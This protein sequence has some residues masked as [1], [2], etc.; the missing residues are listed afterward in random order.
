MILEL[1]EDYEAYKN[2]KNSNK[3]S[4]LEEHGI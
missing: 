2:I 1:L 4:L 3:K